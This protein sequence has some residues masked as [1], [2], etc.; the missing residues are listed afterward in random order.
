MLASY[1]KGIKTL[2]FVLCALFL[3]ACTVGTVC[4]H[5]H[6][7]H[8]REC[9]V[10]L[11]VQTLSTMLC[12]ELFSLLCCKYLLHGEISH[13]DTAYSLNHIPTLVDLKIK[14]SN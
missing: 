13:I 7:S 11:L 2:L 6:N 1:R 10:C 12:V 8:A 3:I 14:L 9:A 5:D 4:P